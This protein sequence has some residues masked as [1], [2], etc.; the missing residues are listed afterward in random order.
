M[1]D[2]IQSVLDKAF[3]LETNMNFM[4]QI[5]ALYKI[6]T[7]NLDIMK[8]ISDFL[9]PIGIMLLLVY[10][11]LAY[12]GDLV[13]RKFEPETFV[14]R[15][16]RLIAGVFVLNNAT[17]FFVGIIN[18]TDTLLSEIGNLYAGDISFPVLTQML[19]NII[20]ELKQGKV[21]SQFANFWIVIGLMGMVSSLNGILKYFIIFVAFIRNIN[22]CRLLAF[23][24]VGL[25]NIY[26]GG[27]KSAAVKYGRLFFAACMEP[28]IVLIGLIFFNILNENLMGTYDP[29]V[30][31][32]AISISSFLGM[33]F[34]VF[35]L[36]IGFLWKSPKLAKEIFC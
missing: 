14:I 2:L 24:P 34:V 16:V 13:E 32:N 23:A 20:D 21:T 29:T 10:W 25:S 4:E 17:S 12:L 31:T 33:S 22:V 7:D 11:T 35:F 26:E 15:F 36:T 5:Q 30:G 27:L 6:P 3:G 8:T 28:I 1:Y 18:F 19:N 9:I